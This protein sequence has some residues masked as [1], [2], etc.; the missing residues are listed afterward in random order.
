MKSL[1]YCVG[2]PAVMALVV[3]IAPDN[4]NAEGVPA[5][6]VMPDASQLASS[7]RTACPAEGCLIRMNG[8]QLIANAEKF[9][10][11]KDFASAM[12]L[13]DALG[14]APQH[15]LQY[16]FLK[17][18]IAAETGDLPTAEKAFRGILQN[19]PDQTRVRLE[20][21][22]VLMM[23]GNE[24]SADYHFRLAQDAEDLPENIAQT[25]RSARSI[26]R[27][28][29]TWNFNFDVGLAPDSNINS[30][31][32]AETVNINYGPFQV[33]LTLNADARKRSGIGQTG[34]F[35]AG[36][37]LRASDKIALLIDSDARFTNYDDKIADNVQVQMAAGPELRIGNT[38]SFSLQAVGEQR[39]YGGRRA[40]TDVGAR[41]AFQKVLSAGQ[42]V[43]V[44]IDSRHTSSNFSRAYS[45]WQVGGNATYEQVIGGTFIASVSLIARKDM[46][47]SKA[48]SNQSYGF[49]AGAGGELPWG[50]NAGISASIS[51]AV[52]DAP[53]Y[54]YSSNV[55]K[56]TRYFGRVYAGL[57]SIKLAGF[58]PSVEYNF[59]K[60]DSNYSLY[61]SDRHRVNFKLARYF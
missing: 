53:Q 7:I 60:I 19:H 30:A 34:G 59:A 50:I 49:N 38:S 33:P 47:E 15:A 8:E 41:A 17:G 22:R 32:S 2:L 6:V 23:R 52:Y 21:A 4:A 56:D 61:A 46:L 9:I 29:R 12:P 16:R 1:K 36:L 48:F 40:N 11:E 10:A 27:N 55:R 26:L 18:Y 43:G 58:S 54:I 45:G 51:R 44:A 31:T 39:W 28:N 42:R 20:L 13:V 35:S 57:R 5:E 14:M 24:S 25:V 3:A 37:R